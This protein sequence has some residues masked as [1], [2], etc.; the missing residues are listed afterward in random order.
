MLHDLFFTYFQGRQAGQNNQRPNEFGHLFKTSLIF[1]YLLFSRT[2]TLFLNKL[3]RF[4][5]II[6]L[7]MNAK[8]HTELCN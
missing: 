5:L 7:L 8:N 2:E 1:V 6:N 4:I 3:N